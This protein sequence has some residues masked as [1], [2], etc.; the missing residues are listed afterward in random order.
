MP[1][2]P[3]PSPAAAHALCRSSSPTFGRYDSAEENDELE[4]AVLKLLD[5]VGLSELGVVLRRIG[6]CSE[7]ALFDMR[8]SHQRIVCRELRRAGADRGSVG[9]KLPTRRR[10]ADCRLRAASRRLPSKA[11]SSAA[12]VAFP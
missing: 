6:L 10:V 7:R 4:P 1:P 8:M 9:R 2:S 5:D 3:S 11:P 12:P